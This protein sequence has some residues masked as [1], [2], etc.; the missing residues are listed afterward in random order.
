[1]SLTREEKK[2]YA[3]ILFVEHNMTQRDIAA[4][5]GIN[6]K[7]INIWVAD[8]KWKELKSSFTISKAEQLKRLYAQITEL[9]DH[10]M[11]R[12][13]GKRFANNKDADT[14]VKI[15]AAIKNLEQDT[16]AA[17]AINIIMRLIHHIRHTNLE[18]AQQLTDAS[19][20]FIK[21]L[22]K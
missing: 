14:L 12:E 4:K 8:G 6:P 9:N 20:T 11:T 1:M 13:Q 22:L 10:I 19:D 18:L 5:V 2:N 7:T 17:E 16:S 21:Q 15:T 3:R